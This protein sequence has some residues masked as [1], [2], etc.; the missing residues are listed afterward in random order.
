MKLVVFGGS[1][2]PLHTGHLFIAE[3]TRNELG[4]DKV[5]F[6]P[7]NI[8]SHKEDF[9]GLSPDKRLDMLAAGLNGYDYF[10]IDACDINRG[11]IS[12]TID[13][14][15]HVYE[16]YSFSGKPGFIIGDDLLDGFRSWK[17][18][19]KLRTLID[20]VVVKRNSIK[21]IDSELPDYYI[22]NSILPVSSTE[23]RN[24]VKLGKT[25][26]HLVPEAVRLKIIQNGYYR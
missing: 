25:I 4:Y 24:R 21:K 2:N 15:E 3:E 8:S 18:V 20:L 6:V 1:F 13:T 12:Y 23:I 19:E 26:R 9:T 22:N 14:I 10:M 16:N 11:G 7:S 17:N 5:L